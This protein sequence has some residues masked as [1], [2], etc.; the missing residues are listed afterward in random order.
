MLRDAIATQPS[1]WRRLVPGGAAMLLSMRGPKNVLRL[2][3]GR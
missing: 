3:A 2:P 1:S